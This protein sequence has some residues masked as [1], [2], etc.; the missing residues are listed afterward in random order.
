MNYNNARSRRIGSMD[1]LNSIKDFHDNVNTVK[2][3]ASSALSNL[4]D[5]NY[6]DY[7]YRNICVNSAEQI[8]KAYEEGNYISGMEINYNNPASRWI[9][10]GYFN[11]KS[12]TFGVDE[13][14]DLTNNVY[15]ENLKDV[16]G[17]WKLFRR[18]YSDRGP[19]LDYWDEVFDDGYNRQRVLI[20]VKTT[21]TRVVSDASMSWGSLSKE[22]TRVVEDVEFINKE[23]EPKPTLPTVSEFRGLV[24]LS[25]NNTSAKHYMEMISGLKLNNSGT[26]APW[27]ADVK[28]NSSELDGSSLIIDVHDANYSESFVNTV[29]N[30]ISKYLFF[31]GAD[32]NSYI[33]AKVN[34]KNK[35]IVDSL[36]VKNAYDTNYKGADE[37]IKNDVY[38]YY[39]E[40]Y[41][42][43]RYIARLTL[44]V[45]EEHIYNNTTLTLSEIMSSNMAI[46]SVKKLADKAKEKLQSAYN[47]WETTEETVRCEEGDPK[48]FYTDIINKFENANYKTIDG[49]LTLQSY[50][51]NAISWINTRTKELL[52]M[53]TDDDNAS[54]LINALSKRLDKNV[55]T[56]MLWYQN[57]TSIDQEEKTIA[58]D[59]II[60]KLNSKKMLVATAVDATDT[61]S[62]SHQV[63]PKYIDINLPDSIFTS[64]FKK[65]DKVYITDDTHAEFS[66]TI[67][68]VSIV[69]INTTSYN[70]MNMEA[71]NNGDLEEGLN[72][73]INCYRLELNNKLPTY[74]CNDN[75][76][77]SLRV[78]KL[79]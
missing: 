40:I 53:T 35:V 33:I 15:T 22:K 21:Y 13:I 38:D 61:N 31:K 16:L 20:D 12:Y 66:A 59:E 1:V 60:A 29:I 71:I 7:K 57:L 69:R 30:N 48:T 73:Q 9:D 27:F 55:G 39:K 62:F 74:Y 10:V 34:K 28:F 47:A 37:M 4:Y 18:Y 54:K 19:V 2:N 45:E 70:D 32:N 46:E 51:R 58:I 41:Y 77:S 63:N 64:S 65:G 14:R 49:C 79:L 67:T 52:K 17:V 50:M 42:N 26:D 56:I 44:W 23:T 6:T 76:V 3:R 78:I 75:D 72:K 25:D 24:T 5:E 43:N 8:S 11:L 68:N 36:D